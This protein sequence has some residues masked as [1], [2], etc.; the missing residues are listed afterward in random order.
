VSDQVAGVLD[1]NDPI[2][3]SYNL[4]VSSPGF[5]RPL[6]TLDHL[7]RFT[8]H[9]VRLNLHDKFAGH[10]KITGEIT[11]VSESGVEINMDGTVYQVSAE[12][13][14]KARLVPD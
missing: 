13:I 6:F 14:D 8:G 3:G 7:R 2:K 12:N 9:I 11:A 4:E 10:R 1:V 5:D